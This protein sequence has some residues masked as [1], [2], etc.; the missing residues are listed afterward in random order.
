MDKEFT[1]KLKLSNEGT[2]DVKIDPSQTVLKL[3]ELIAKQRNCEVN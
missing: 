2:F 3:K 1:I